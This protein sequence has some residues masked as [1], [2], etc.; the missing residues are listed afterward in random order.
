MNFVACSIKKPGVDENHSLS[1]LVYTTP[2]VNRGA[3]LF[4][5]DSHFKRQ[6]SQAETRL[7]CAEQLI[8]E[9][10]LLGPVHLWL[11][12]VDA[13]SARIFSS[14]FAQKVI[15]GNGASEVP[16]QNPLGCLFATAP[17]YRVAGHQMAYIPNEQ[18]T[19]AR[20]RQRLSSMICVHT[21]WRHFSCQHATVFLET[22][23]KVAPHQ[24]EPVSVNQRLVLRVYCRHRILTVLNRCQRGFHDDVFDRG[25][26]GCTDVMIWVDLQLDVEPIIF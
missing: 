14:G 15:H 25:W 13:T 9:G 16:V 18:N 7:N 1:C 20:E 8:S 2:Q 17:E 24:P 3:A 5:H 4:I 22:F 19:A 26:M 12:N 6:R 11:H 21:I 23:L 10:N